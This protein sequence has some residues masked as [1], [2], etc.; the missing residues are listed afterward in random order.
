MLV[1]F[2][3][4]VYQ[5]ENCFCRSAFESYN[6]EKVIGKKY[7]D[8]FFFFFVDSLGDI[9]FDSVFQHFT[10]V[11][12]EFLKW[13]PRKAHITVCFSF[14]QCCSQHQTVRV[15][16]F[17][18]ASGQTLCLM[19]WSKQQLSSLSS[20]NKTQLMWLNLPWPCAFL[21]GNLLCRNYV[22]SE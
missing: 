20:K 22:P 4:T 8:I 14:W 3:H 11:V 21:C 18:H 6:E 16:V 13:C 10:I 15:Q 17:Q 5:T 7:R 1:F 19:C 2:L 12:T 9:V